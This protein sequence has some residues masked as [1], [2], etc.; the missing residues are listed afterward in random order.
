MFEELKAAWNELKLWEQVALASVCSF[1][2]LVVYGTLIVALEKWKT[3]AAGSL[4]F[5]LILTMIIVWFWWSVLSVVGC[6][7]DPR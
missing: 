4:T 5:A 6:N 3:G 1:V 2:A 7:D